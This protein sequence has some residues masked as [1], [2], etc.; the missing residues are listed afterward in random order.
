MSEPGSGHIKRDFKSGELKPCPF[1]GSKLLSNMNN[2]FVGCP[3]GCMIDH[4]MISIDKWNNAWAYKQIEE[5]K[6]ENSLLKS[7][8]ICV[9]HESAAC[10]ECVKEMQSLETRVAELEQEN[11]GLEGCK[12]VAER[13]V[14]ELEKEK[15]LVSSKL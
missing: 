7:Q 6:K 9:K 5:L 12:L 3:S 2:L 14:V 13:K 8:Y 15:H 1:C 10:N 4:G 11:F